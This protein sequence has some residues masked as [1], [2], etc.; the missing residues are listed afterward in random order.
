M[1]NNNL[2]Q[3]EQETDFV[4]LRKWAGRRQE[5]QT[6][7][8]L[9]GCLL[10]MSL[11][12]GGGMPCMSSHNGSNEIC[13]HISRRTVCVCAING[14]F[15]C[16]TSFSWHVAASMPFFTWVNHGSLPVPFIFIRHFSPFMAFNMLYYCILLELSP[17]PPHLS[18]S[19]HHSPM[20]NFF[21]S[22]SPWAF[23]FLL[24][25]IKLHA[26]FCVH[27]LMMC[28]GIDHVL[29]V[30]LSIEISMVWKLLLCVFILSC[31]SPSHVY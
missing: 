14:S 13:Q 28:V 26:F 21:F 7:Q 4:C 8:C 24:L 17:M 30:G 6:F 18:C 27:A 22:V 2:L 20:V 15:M 19:K 1:H 5:G 16:E 29:Q 12:G 3:K 23:W 25:Y 11:W 9:C 31:P 10:T